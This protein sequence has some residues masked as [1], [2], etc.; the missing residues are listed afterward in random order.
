MV[1]LSCN[2][3]PSSTGR[4][5]SSASPT[6]PGNR[7]PSCFLRGGHLSRLL[8]LGVHTRT[9]HRGGHGTLA[10]IRRICWIP[11]GLSTV[12]KYLVDCRSCPH[13]NDQPSRTARRPLPRHRTNPAPPISTVGADHFGPTLSSGPRIK[14]KP[15]PAQDSF[16]TRRLDR[17][18]G[19]LPNGL[20]SH[21][22][23]IPNKTF[24][25]RSLISTAY[26]VDV[27]G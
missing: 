7:H 24:P 5:E 10:E 6:K 16:S 2:S 18:V 22:R 4:G 17:P 15:T 14:T 3:A 9:N 23:Q 25:A 12:K 26:G 20:R 21:S 1:P 19:R 27:G 11:N 8:V 13:L